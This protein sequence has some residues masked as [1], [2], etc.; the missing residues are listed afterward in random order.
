[1]YR[2]NVTPVV[3]QTSSKTGTLM[4]SVVATFNAVG[5]DADVRETK[6]LETP[7]KE[8]ITRAE[9]ENFIV[10]VRCYI[11]VFLVGQYMA[12]E[13]FCGG[14]G[15]L[16]LG[17]D[18]DLG[19]APKGRHEK[20]SCCYFDERRIILAVFTHTDDD[21]QFYTRGVQPTTFVRTCKTFGF[22]C[23]EPKQIL[24]INARPPKCVIA[25]D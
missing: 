25:Q 13:N 18:R 20:A 11:D 12:N 17:G 3:S 7:A 2:F 1:M 9:I 24:K 4:E 21:D 15:G 10:V 5:T 6:A 19:F 14:E 22:F 16:Q 8:T 23:E